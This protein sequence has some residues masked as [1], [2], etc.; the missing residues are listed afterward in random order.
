MKLKF[1]VLLMLLGNINYAFSQTKAEKI[2]KLLE[3]C[4]YNAIGEQMVESYGK[5]YEKQLNGNQDALEAIKDWSKEGTEAMFDS[6]VLIY[7]RLFTKQDIDDMLDF[8]DT[9]VGKKIIELTPTIMDL[10]TQAGH[11]WAEANAPL[12]EEKLQPI[13]E[14]EKNK[15]SFESLYNPDE[16]FKKL[17]PY[18]F[19]T[20]QKAKSGFKSEQFP[21]TIHYDEK[22]WTEL[23]CNKINGMA[24]AC[25]Y[26]EG[27]DTFSMIIAENEEGDLP[28]LKAAALVNVYKVASDVV[29]KEVGM[30]EVNGQELLK[31]EMDA[32]IN[33]YELSY[34]NYYLS[35]DW[36]MIQ[37][38]SFGG[39]EGFKKQFDNIVDMNNGIVVD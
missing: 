21:Y 7:D 31:M 35:T 26:I 38:I 1:I 16:E 39:K 14:A 13:I 34:Y 5:I 17:N 9:E 20:P 22:I 11:N 36:G 18:T 8:Y 37:V 28:Y 19:S 10:T 4:D 33:D 23:D 12:L 24:D 15:Y 25:F 27:E 30:L 2:H 6:L 3:A 32:S 29:V